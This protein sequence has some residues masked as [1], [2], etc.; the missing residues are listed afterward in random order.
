MTIWHATPQ[1]VPPTPR[2]CSTTAPGFAPNYRM[3]PF[4]SMHV[5][6]HAGFAWFCKLVLALI[7]S[8]LPTFNSMVFDQ[9][10]L[11]G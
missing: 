3:D 6:S 9:T 11:R 1:S 10:L 4:F 8:R 5:S 2:R 7:Y